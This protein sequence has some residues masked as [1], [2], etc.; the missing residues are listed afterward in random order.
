MNKKV[1]RNDPCPCGS[2]KKYKNCCF[3][4]TIGPKK[5]K[6]TWINP[7]KQQQQAVPTGVN[8]MERTFGAAI[9]AAQRDEKPP[10]PSSSIPPEE[11]IPPG[12]VAEIPPE[13]PVDE[14]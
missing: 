1:G 6:A 10:L 9:A 11:V 7:A 13:P 12:P 4:K 2:G 8:L 5:F 3:S 14:E